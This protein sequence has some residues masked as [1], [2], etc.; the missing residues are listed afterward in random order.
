MLHEYIILYIFNILRQQKS[1]MFYTCWK[2]TKDREGTLS[3][4][5]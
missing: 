4:M 3:N 5:Q 2:I 1:Q